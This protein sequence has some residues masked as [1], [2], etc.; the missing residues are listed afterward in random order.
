M[1]TIS[2]SVSVSIGQL[3]RIHSSYGFDVGEGKIEVLDILEPNHE[4]VQEIIK[5]MVNQYNDFGRIPF[6][7]LDRDSQMSVA[8][9]YSSYWIKYRNC[10]KEQQ[11]HYGEINY[12]TLEDF[13]D[14][15]SIL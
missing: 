8:H 11:E 10:D 12:L 13:V 9:Y 15:T 4:E 14:H 7:Q 3:L 6:E 5:M 2:K 1:K